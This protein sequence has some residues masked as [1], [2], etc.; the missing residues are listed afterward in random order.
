MIDLET[1][2]RLLLEKLN[3]GRERGFELV[4][5]SVTEKEYGWAFHYASKGFLETRD[6]KYAVAGG[7]P[8]V[9]DR[10]DGS[11]HFLG[12]LKRPEVLIAEYDQQRHKNCT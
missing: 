4:I 7:G 10:E 11:I 12:T 2:K 9:V 6:P 8:A 1:A 3:A 5:T